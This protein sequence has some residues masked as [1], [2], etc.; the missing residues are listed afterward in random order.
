MFKELASNLLRKVKEVGA[1]LNATVI[2][3][4][5]GDAS[6]AMDTRDKY[7]FKAMNETYRRPSVCLS[8]CLT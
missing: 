6:A 5:A 3:V 7:V 4:D 8:Y 1:K 2:M